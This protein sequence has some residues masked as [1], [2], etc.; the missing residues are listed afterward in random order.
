MK[1]IKRMQGCLVGATV[2]WCCGFVAAWT[3]ALA[4]NAASAAEPVGDLGAADR[5]VVRG[6]EAIPAESLREGLLGDAD[7]Y[8][9]GLPTADRDAYL[10]SLRRRATV[11]LETAGF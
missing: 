2:P 7:V 3:A 4:V 10:A 8:W 1:T 5:L 9:L 6:L 11:A